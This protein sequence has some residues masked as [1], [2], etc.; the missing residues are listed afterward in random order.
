MCCTA[1]L[2]PKTPVH[3]INYFRKIFFWPN[4]FA[5]W[6]PNHENF[7]LSHRVLFVPINAYKSSAIHCPARFYKKLVSWDILKTIAHLISILA[8]ICH[9]KWNPP[10][11]SCILFCNSLFLWMLSRFYHKTLSGAVDISS[12]WLL[13]Q[14]KIN[15]TE[16]TSRWIGQSI[17]WTKKP[18]MEVT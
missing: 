9:W 4:V 5:S 13:C 8:T 2:S 3:V 15:T 7:Y 16:V 18:Q 11:P 14:S 17:S 10:T 12:M 6:W 1:C